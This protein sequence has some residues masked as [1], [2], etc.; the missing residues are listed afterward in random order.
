M[1]RKVEETFEKYNNRLEYLRSYVL[2]KFGTC[3]S[4]ELDTLETL[5]Q[6]MDKELQSVL[7]V[8]LSHIDSYLRYEKYYFVDESNGNDIWTEEFGT[9]EE[10]NAYAERAWR[11]KTEHEKNHKHNVNV[12]T[13]SLGGDMTT[14]DGFF[15]SMDE[16]KKE[17]DRRLGK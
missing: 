10:A 16:R 13:L 14:E 11:R 6:N 5:V 9:L 1:M 2:H 8:H 4:G 12:Y 15:N 3:G 17:L 7:D